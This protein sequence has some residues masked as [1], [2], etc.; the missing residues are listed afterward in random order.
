[1]PTYTYRCET[2]EEVFEIKQRI[3]EDPLE[4]KPDC[5]KEECSVQRIIT[6][7]NFILKGAGWYRDGYSSKKKE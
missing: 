3:T 1:M 7:G 5:E 6:N 4:N 2:C